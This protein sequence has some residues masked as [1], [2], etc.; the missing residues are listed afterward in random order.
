MTRL[1][2]AGSCQKYVEKEIGRGRWMDFGG[3]TPSVVL[4]PVRICQWVLDVPDK[5]DAESESKHLEILGCL[6]ILLRL[7][8]TK[9]TWYYLCLLTSLL[10]R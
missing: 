3:P 2:V 10:F 5:T 6:I 7:I 1:K 9:H 4:G 8:V